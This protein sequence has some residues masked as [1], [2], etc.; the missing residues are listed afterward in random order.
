MPRWR[1]RIRFTLR[2][3]LAAVFAIAVVLA[4]VLACRKRADRLTQMATK[5]AAKAQEY[6]D[7]AWGMQ[8]FGLQSPERD[9]QAGRYWNLHAE[10][11]DFSKLCRQ[12]V[13]RPWVSI[14]N[15]PSL[16][17]ENPSPEGDGR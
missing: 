4:V 14:R 15:E 13:W 3:L 12:A 8:R 9:V 7:V 16:E 10:H 2:T 5:H 1:F 11:R 17:H 6:A